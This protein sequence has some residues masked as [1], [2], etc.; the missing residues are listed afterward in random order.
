MASFLAA[1]G[2]VHIAEAN[3]ELV[4]ES[5]AAVPTSEQQSEYGLRNGSAL[6]VPIPFSNPAIGAG[7]SLGAGYL[8]QLAPDADTSFLGLGAMRSN[9]GSEAYGLGGNLAFGSGWTFDFVVAEAAL[10]YDLF[11]DDLTFPVEQ[12]GTLFRGGV[13][14]EIVQANTLGFNFRYLDSNVALREGG[15]RPDDISDDSDLELGSF[16]LSYDWDLRDD[17]DYPTD[18][19]FF[20]VSVNR[21]FSL[22]NDTR[23][24]Q[25]ASANFDMFRTVG[26]EK[27]V[28]GR[29]TTCATSDDTPF[30]DKCSIGITDGFR[31]FSPTRFYDTR[32]FSAQAEYR[33]RVGQRFGFVV[34]GGIGWTGSSYGSL[35]DNGD[36]IAGGVGLRYRVTEQFPVDLSLDVSTNNEDEEFVYIFVGQRF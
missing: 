1:F 36:R 29:L 15:I 5:L 32:L 26:D 13:A 30:F 7:L 23:S 14:Y 12:T 18:G 10:R 8:F 34:F 6:V 3:P 16:G 17:G 20:G 27:V 22:K 2:L 21:G 4:E 33:Q 25:Y 11:V 28:G 35:T 9:N 31:G 19:Y 24:Y